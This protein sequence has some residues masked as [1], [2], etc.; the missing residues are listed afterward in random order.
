MRKAVFKSVGSCLVGMGLFIGAGISAHAVLV[1][2]NDTFSAPPYVNN[3]TI[4]GQNGWQKFTGDDSSMIITNDPTGSGRGTV[5]YLTN[6]SPSGYW[7]YQTFD[8]AFATNDL[9]IRFDIYGTKPDPDAI[10]FPDVIIRDAVGLNSEAAALEARGNG[11]FRLNGNNSLVVPG[12]TAQ[13]GKWYTVTFNFSFNPKLY[14]F[15]ITDGV[16]T[17]AL[18][19]VPFWSTAN[20]VGWIT[21][22]PQ[23]FGDTFEGGLV[24]NVIVA[25]PEPSAVMFTLAGFGTFLTLRRARRN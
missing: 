19:N 9:R 7:A 3:T 4:I 5:L 22:R 10:V 1:P 20:G 13:G 24:D 8:Q 15:E 17:G 11:V 12:I 18:Y 6:A 25:V 23:N 14:N 16:S 21:F 2:Y